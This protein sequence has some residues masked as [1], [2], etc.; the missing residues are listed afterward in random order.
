MAL[1]IG[2]GITLGG[3]ISLVVESGG[4]GNP[5][6]FTV[7]DGNTVSI[8]TAV[9]ASGRVTI[10]TNGEQAVLSSSS[11]TAGQTA[12]LTGTGGPEVITF[13]Y[14][15]N[16]NDNGNGTW[17]YEIAIYENPPSQTWD[18]IELTA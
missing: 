8:T 1:E 11:W 15:N 17:T 6:L 10:V 7:G 18:S 2:A 12:T 13:D 4:G 16:Q 14:M 5:N 9:G 3:G